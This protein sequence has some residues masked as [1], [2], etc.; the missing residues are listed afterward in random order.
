M[1]NE[2]LYESFAK[3]TSMR[4]VIR[5]GD[6]LLILR[7]EAPGFSLKIGDIVVYDD[8]FSILS[9]LQFCKARCETAHRILSLGKGFYR[10]KGDETARIDVIKQL[11][12]IGRV[13]GIN[14]KFL[15]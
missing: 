8:H 7:K 4:P 2:Y 14:N 3:G 9:S 12:V 6:R 13:I 15:G 11:D 10:V 5:Q 1:K